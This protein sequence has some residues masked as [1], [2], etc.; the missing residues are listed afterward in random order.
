MARARRTRRPFS[1]R[2]ATHLTWRGLRMTGEG[3]VLPQRS[4]PDTSGKAQAK[5]RGANSA[6]TPF[7]LPCRR[8]S[9]PGCGIFAKFV[10]SLF[11]IFIF[12][13]YLRQTL[14]SLSSERLSFSRT[15]P[16]LPLTEV[17]VHVLTAHPPFLSASISSLP[18][19]QP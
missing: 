13:C 9:L 8:A 19:T 1:T 14:P 15:S 12:P 5:G 7:H 10:I 16:S 17:L 4:T 2:H 6:R 3:T 11:P 18:Y